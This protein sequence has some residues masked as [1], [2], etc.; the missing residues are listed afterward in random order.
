MYKLPDTYV[1][2]HHSLDAYLMLRYMKLLVVMTFVGC[3]ITWPILFPINATGGVGNKQFDMLSMSNVQNKARYFAH[4]FVGWIFFGF[5]FFLVTRESIFYINLR[6]AYAFSPAYANRL[7]SRTVMF[8]SVPQDYLDEKKLRRM[9]GA[10]RVKNVWIATDTSKLEEKVKDRDAAAMKLEGAETALIKQANVARLKAMKKNPNADEQLEAT[11]D[12]T[13]SGSIAARWVRPKD[14]P[15]H[16]L[17]FLIGK[18]VDTID[19][20]RAEI[21]RLNPEIEEEQAKHRAA[22]AKKVSAV[23]VE[24]YNQNDA[25]AAYQSVAHNQPLHMAPRYIGVDPTQVI[26]SNLR[27][28]WWERV[29]RNFATIAFICVLIIFWAIPVA[30]V[31]S[32]SNID[33]LIARLPW[34]GFINHVPTFIRGVITGLLP[35]VLLAV[36]MALLP[37]IIRC[38]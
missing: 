34:L 30:F 15:T 25:Q 27:I 5:V 24:F 6:Q 28:M 23:F 32:I 20:A 13:E 29:L 18:K 12:H 10:E 36:L 31:G 3:C 22:D 8:S 9:F 26:W 2:Q 38:T 19:W 7:S 17:K 11:A 16:R 1:L 35:S 4:A 33:S 37:I 21:E 14:R